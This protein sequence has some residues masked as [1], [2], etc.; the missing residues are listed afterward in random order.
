MIL[1]ILI[2]F[3]PLK[4]Y[5]KICISALFLLLSIFV[6]KI[7]AK[8]IKNDWESTVTFGVGNVG[9]MNNFQTGILQSSFSLLFRPFE[10][11]KNFEAKFKIMTQSPSK[12]DDGFIEVPLRDYDFSKIAELWLRY[13]IFNQ[14]ELK[15]GRFP[16]TPDETTPLYW[17]YYS[18]YSKIDF[19]KDPEINPFIIV[20]QDLLSVYSYQSNRSTATNI[21][22]TRVELDLNSKMT[23]QNLEL[24]LNLKSNYDQ[25][26]DPDYALSSLSIGR[27]QYIDKTVT[28]HD[29][30]YRIV[31]FYS[32]FSLDY[33]NLIF[34]KIFLKYWKNL[35]SDVFNEGKIF[36]IEE[37]IHFKTNSL[38]F[39]Y[40]KYYA[41]Q[42][43][44]PPSSLSSYYYPGFQITALDVKFSQDFLESWNAL[45][46]YRYQISTPYGQSSDI[47]ISPGAVPVIPK[48]KISLL[49]E[50]HFDSSGR[51]D[52]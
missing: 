40:I 51:Q 35:D 7:Y 31:N 41:E 24:K 22:R 28:Y 49:L 39:A 36:G 18:L 29:Q 5:R 46:E 47:S 9:Y 38:S 16:D 25:F 32:D 19:Y 37:K 2:L 42:S 43:S 52:N 50:Y 4:S 23:S 20:R 26:S 12:E 6:S 15:A 10:E 44:V 1:H 17:P 34:S 8:E 14:L 45:L 33:D 30:K 21:E 13:L 3:L 27:E 48:Y 11:N